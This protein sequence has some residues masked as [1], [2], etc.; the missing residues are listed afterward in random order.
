M[1]QT[2][3]RLPESI[4]FSA[5][6]EIRAVVAAVFPTVYTG[7]MLSFFFFL[8]LNDPL[9]KSYFVL[10]MAL[11]FSNEIYTFSTSIKFS[12]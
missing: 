11:A 10:I 9:I 5:V 4:R 2:W 6:E 8:T 7:E 12:S 3:L 1:L